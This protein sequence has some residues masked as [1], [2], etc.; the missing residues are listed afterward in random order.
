MN[1]GWLQDEMLQ[2]YI[3]TIFDR[4]DK[5]RSGS[6]DPQEMTFFFNDLFKAL[7]INRTITQQDSMN[8]IRSIDQNSDGLVN[9]QELFL[10]FKN[11][12]SK[13]EAI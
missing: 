2:N 9:K 12:L 10:A 13:R 1:E 6:L 7:N 11:M 3:N 8:A 4:Y 5:D